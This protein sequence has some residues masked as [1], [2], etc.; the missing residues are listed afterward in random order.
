MFGL[1]LFF[2]WMLIIE[3][4]KIWT[5]VFFKKILG[6]K[7]VIGLLNELDKK[8]MITNKDNF[9][10]FKNSQSKNTIEIPV[11]GRKK[12]IHGYAAMLCSEIHLDKKYMTKLCELDINY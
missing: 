4:S 1:Q 10:I 9:K 5:P 8:F 7:K 11:I 3:S 2:C 12:S 6:D